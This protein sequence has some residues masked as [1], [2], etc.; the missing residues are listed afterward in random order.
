V[1]DLGRRA[2]IVCAIAAIGVG[3]YLAFRPSDEARIRK[4]LSKLE[5]AV[6]VT[7]ADMQKNPIG[8]LSHV[9]SAFEPLF[10]PEVRV[11]VPEL[12]SLQ[13]G[14]SELVELVAGAPRFVR[15]F[16]V[17]LGSVTVKMD[18]AGESA[19][20]GAIA[21]VKALDRDEKVREEKRAVD[22][23]FAKQKGEWIITTV[24]VWAKG[25]ASP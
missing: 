18:E 9:S 14:R 6:R 11:S 19:A 4:Q 25:D 2:A 17:E 21:E 8:R 13:S 23:R 12:T 15:T 20:V 3:S 1:K 5:A 22:F 16:E 24:S 10:D 7:E